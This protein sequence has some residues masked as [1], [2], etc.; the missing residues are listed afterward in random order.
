MDFVNAYNLNQSDGSFRDRACFEY[1]NLAEDKKA[2][3]LADEIL[4]IEEFN[5]SAWYVKCLF[6]ED[7]SE[8][9]NI[10]PKILKDNNDFSSSLIIKVIQSE[11]IRSYDD[12]KKYGL[13]YKF[14]INEFTEVT[15]ANKTKWIVNINLLL[16]RFFIE[17]PIRYISGDTFITER[18]PSIDNALKLLD[19]FIST[20]ITTELSDS[21]MIY[22]FHYHYLKYLVENN[23]EDLKKIQLKYK[24]LPTVHWSYTVSICQVLNHKG[25]FEDSLE[26]LDEYFTKQVNILINIIFLK[27]SFL[28]LYKNLRCRRNVHWLFEFKT[29]FGRNFSFTY[30]FNIFL[31]FKKNT[32]IKNYFRGNI[33]K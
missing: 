19:K 32:V 25:R 16:D 21:L 15:F 24:D 12:L 29:N 6:L 10:L 22:E 11:G 20:L 23:D 30:F 3:T 4:K 17:F 9:P 27:Q 28:M 31:I 33:L 5:A 1:L 13:E 14:N 8:I 18:N 2:K 26:I 7:F